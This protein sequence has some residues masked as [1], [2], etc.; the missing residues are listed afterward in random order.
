M[1]GTPLFALAI[2]PPR[3]I[4]APMTVPNERLDPHPAIL[5]WLAGFETGH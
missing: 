3:L 5:G 4:D 2:R 1:N